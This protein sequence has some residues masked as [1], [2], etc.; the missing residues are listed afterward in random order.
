VTPPVKTVKGPRADLRSVRG[1][2]DVRRLHVRGPGVESLAGIEGF[3]DLVGLR[4]EKV[5]APDLERLRALRGIRQLELDEVSGPL[6]A[7]AITAL[8]HLQML[9]IFARERSVAEAVGQLDLGRL[10]RLDY[11]VLQ[12]LG[13]PPF[14]PVRVDWLER[15]PAVRLLH[16]SGFVFG[17][18]ETERVCALAGQFEQF[19]F[20]PASARQKARIIGA[21]PRGVAIAGD[22]KAD[23]LREIREVRPGEWEIGLL[24]ADEWQTETT[25]DAVEWLERELERRDSALAARI[26]VDEDADLVFI[27]A[28]SRSDLAAVER[29][30]GE[31]T[32]P[33]ADWDPA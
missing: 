8:P 13:P 14:V 6:D 23:A 16:W 32:P 19:A 2:A 22:A 7:A 33:P 26:Q 29:I 28:A 30:A 21:F 27:T 4:L 5:E 9:Q 24:L 3:H 18:A 1:A 25:G 31:M 20:T 17:D 15:A 10:P 11:V 12:Y